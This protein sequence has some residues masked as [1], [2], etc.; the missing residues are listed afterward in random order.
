MILALTRPSRSADL[1]LLDMDHFRQ[2]PE[3]IS[4][5]PVG[6]SKQAK[7]VRFVRDFFFPKF[8]ADESICP[9][10]TVKHYMERTEPLRMIGPVRNSSLFLSWIK[11]HRPISSASVARWLKTVLS[12]A[13]ID[14][15]LFKAHSRR[16]ASVS[17]AANSGITT[18]EILE[19]ADWSTDSVFQKFY[20]K[21]V[22]L[23]FLKLNKLQNTPLICET[24]LLKYNFRMAKAAERLRDYIDNI[25]AIKSSHFLFN[26][27]VG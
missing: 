21:P 10:I 4:F 2:R 22:K 24:D 1:C 20:Y 23:Y 7:G 8:L 9:V 13:G 19:A 17:A 5:I 6:L 3:G 18:K 15:S 25:V 26:H 11:P 16:G 14:T 12:K 27:V